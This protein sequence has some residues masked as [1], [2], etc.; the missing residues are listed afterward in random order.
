MFKQDHNEIIARLAH[1][2]PKTFFENPRQRAP[3]KI[4]IVSDIE[5]QGC[6]ELIG[7]DLGEA[8]EWYISHIGYAYC[9]ATPGKARVDLDGNQVSKVTEQEASVA[10][11][12]IDKYNADKFRMKHLTSVQT[13]QP[14][15]ENEQLRRTAV[16]ESAAA[17]NERANRSDAELIENATKK[18]AR[19]T[20]LLNSEDDEFKARFLMQVLKEV[21]A[22]IDVM[23]QRLVV[24]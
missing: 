13:I 6:A 17:D 5:K 12:K 1:L 10:Q 16:R 14:I 24:N 23:L 22:D 4:D 8:V 21:R 3:L 19:A 20:S 11:Q 15:N 7:V 2:F 9:M 18:L